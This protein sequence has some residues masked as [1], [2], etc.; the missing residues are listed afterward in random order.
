MTQ[1][2]PDP[3]A[4]ARQ[5]ADH[6]NQNRHIALNQRIERILADCRQLDRDQ[7]TTGL[8]A[9]HRRRMSMVPPSSKYPEAQPWVEFTLARDR[10]VQRLAHLSDFDM[11]VIRSLDLYVTFHTIRLTRFHLRPT[12]HVPERFVIDRAIRVDG[13]SCRSEVQSC[14]GRSDSAWLI[15]GAAA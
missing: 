9:F 3:L 1:R 15:V 7:L 13:G 6:I 2:I 10:E 11:A 4:A 12:R 5:E 8:E 14:Q